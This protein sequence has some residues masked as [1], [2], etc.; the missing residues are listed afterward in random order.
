MIDIYD[1]HSWHERCNSKGRTTEHFYGK[2]EQEGENKM[3]AQEL[4][5]IARAEQPSVKYAVNAKNTVIGAYSDT[6][7][8]FIPVAA[9]ALTGDWYNIPGEILINGQPSH[10]ETWIE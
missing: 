7:G 6:L 2:T 5:K 10:G 9:L 4:L 1:N 8:R 3:T